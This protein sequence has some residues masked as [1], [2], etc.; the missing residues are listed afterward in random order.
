MP[1]RPVILIVDDETRIRRLL[2]EEFEK[3]GFDVMQ[4]QDG[5]QALEMFRLAS[6]EPDLVVLDYMMPVMDGVTTLKALRQISNVPVL[7]LTA[8][9]FLSDKKL[10]FSEGADDYLVK[11]FAMEELLLRVQALL[12]RAATSTSPLSTAAADV[13][14]ENGPLSLS[15]AQ[16]SAFWRGARL[17]L[18]EREYR[19]LEALVKKAGSIIRYEQLLQVGWQGSTEA[20]VSHL[21]VAMARL[22]KKLATAG[23]N[24]K[25]LSSFTHVGYLLGDLSHYDT[26]YAV[27]ESEET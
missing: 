14:I 9:D 1:L 21:R 6:V 16:S 12:R 22:R 10:A 20:D 8:R 18:T 17:P 27:L 26:D 25:I 19:L 11:P 13:R 23:A 4:A 5:E 2:A 3:V 15:P 24:P 7:M